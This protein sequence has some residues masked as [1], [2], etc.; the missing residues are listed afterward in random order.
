MSSRSTVEPFCHWSKVRICSAQLNLWGPSKRR[1]SSNKMH[2]YGYLLMFAGNGGKNIRYIYHRN[3][4]CKRGWFGYYSYGFARAFRHSNN[5]RHSVI[6]SANIS[7][8]E[9]SNNVCFNRIGMIWRAVDVDW[10]I[11]KP[12]YLNCISNSISML[13]GLSIEDSINWWWNDRR[14]II[15]TNRLEIKW[16]SF[17][18]TNLLVSNA[19]SD[20]N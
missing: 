5:S 10:T 16:K 14:H 13:L 6:L 11:Q 15:Q 20:L 18:W 9:F 19:H 7:K 12:V 4:Y 2:N 3:V 17:E 8:K 1:F